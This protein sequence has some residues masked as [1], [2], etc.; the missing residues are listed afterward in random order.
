MH[1][2]KLSHWIFDT[3]GYWVGQV[4]QLGE[5]DRKI[6]DSIP[7]KWRAGVMW[8]AGGQK[9]V[10][11]ICP[12]GGK[13]GRCRRIRAGP[14]LGEAQCRPVHPRHW[15]RAKEVSRFLQTISENMCG[16]DSD[17]RDESS[18]WKQQQER[19][20]YLAVTVLW[21]AFGKVSVPELLR[22]INDAAISPEQAATEEW[23]GEFHYQTLT[24][25]FAAKK[26]PMEANDLELALCFWLRE[27]PALADRTR[28]SIL[29]GVTGTLH[30]FCAG[31]ARVLLSEETTVTPDDVLAGKWIVINAC[32]SDFGDTGC[33]INAAWKFLLQRRL[34]KRAAQPGDSC[35][36]IVSDESQ[37]YVNSHDAAF[38][39]QSRSHLASMVYI[40]QGV[41]SFYGVMGGD[42]GIHVADS[43]MANFT[44]CI[45]HASDAIS[46]RWANEKIG[47]RLK[48]FIGTSDSPSMS[49]SEELIGISK[50]SM[51]TSSHMEVILECN[52]MQN[53]LRCGGKAAN[54]IAD[55]AV[56]KVGECFASTGENFIF[57]PF[58]QK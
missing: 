14:P 45:L 30:T 15:G 35:C 37:L 44:H 58:S 2:E 9:R 41:S 38:L 34:L 12:L 19:V 29:V 26:S 43:L 7:E 28:S 40:T 1:P 21:I 17:G 13:G 25:A 39:S 10:A 48:T 57:V 23:K 4:E 16:S 6:F 51:N 32:A 42:K 11:G 53:N 55:A 8:K 20:I 47:R 18:F 54:Y 3:G 5:I 36:W 31:Y 46:A 22:F 52:L 49:V 50:M 24:K 56:I 33:L 27:Y